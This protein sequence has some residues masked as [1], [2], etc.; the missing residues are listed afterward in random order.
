[1][2]KDFATLIREFDYQA[3]P[4]SPPPYK[5][6]NIDE[7]R[8]QEANDS[9]NTGPNQVAKFHHALTMCLLASNLA[10]STIF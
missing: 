3:G 1:M 9:A 8:Q 7:L 10:N 2:G 4:L 6:R 5:N